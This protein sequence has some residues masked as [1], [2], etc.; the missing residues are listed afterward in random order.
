M[1]DDDDDWTTAEMEVLL[2]LSTSSPNIGSFAP[3]FSTPLRSSFVLLYTSVGVARARFKL[4]AREKEQERSARLFFCVFE[5]SVT[6]TTSE[7]ASRPLFFLRPFF[8][9]PRP[10]FFLSLSFLKNTPAAA[11]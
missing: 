9:Q 8:S 1:N 11:R 7:R 2:L 10:F 6:M 3:R 4:W 5:G